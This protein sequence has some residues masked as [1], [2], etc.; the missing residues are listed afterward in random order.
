MRKFKITKRLNGSTCFGVNTIAVIKGDYTYCG[1]KGLFQ[2]WYEGEVGANNWG[3]CR[4]YKSYDEALKEL[5]KHYEYIEE[6]TEPR[7]ELKCIGF[8]RSDTFLIADLDGGTNYSK[9]NPYTFDENMSV[10]N[11]EGD[12]EVDA[13]GY[14]LA[15]N[16]AIRILP[17]EKEKLE[18]RQE[19]LRE[20]ID[21]ENLADV[22]EYLEN[23]SKLKELE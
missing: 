2:I 18:Q 6:I 7:I 5:A 3:S 1:T 23:E 8:N 20:K 22:I 12:I 4:G 17:T 9:N 15:G 11:C 10:V 19:E 21:K 14:I 16:C 13:I